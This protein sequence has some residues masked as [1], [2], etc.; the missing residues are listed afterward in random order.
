MTNPTKPQLAVLRKMQEGWKLKAVRGFN[1]SAWLSDGKRR[2]TIS[3]PTILSLHA[4]GL[5]T[6][7]PGFGIQELLL[8]PKGREAAEGVD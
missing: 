2:D 8:T 1:F 7:P 3:F 5:I 4:K 6:N